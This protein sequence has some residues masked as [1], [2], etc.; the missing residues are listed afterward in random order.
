[1]VAAGLAGAARATA[2]LLLGVSFRGGPDDAGEAETGADLAGAGVTVA[3]GASL[4][5]FKALIVLASTGLVSG[6]VAALDF[7]AGG[8]SDDEAE[9]DGEETG[10]GGEAG[11]R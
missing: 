7:S 4:S 3:A 6:P 9:G 10:W 8:A 1:V 2:P 11:G 5:C